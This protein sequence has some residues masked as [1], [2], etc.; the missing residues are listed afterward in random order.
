M[1]NINFNLFCFQNFPDFFIFSV[2][3]EIFHCPD[4][5][6][7]FLL[8]WKQLSRLTT[9]IGWVSSGHITHP[10]FQ[11]VIMPTKPWKPHNKTVHKDG[12]MLPPPHR[13]L[14][15]CPKKFF[16]A[17]FRSWTGIQK[18]SSSE[19][20]CLCVRAGGDKRGWLPVSRGQLV[21]FSGNLVVVIE[22]T[23]ALH[24]SEHARPRSL[25]FT[26]TF[27]CLPCIFWF[28]W[29]IAIHRRCKKKISLS[30]FLDWLCN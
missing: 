28:L 22:R 23:R 25:F 12:G 15:Q 10:S 4:T 30:S 3:K 11:A 5:S 6:G 8:Q 16:Y 27:F 1:S 7:P 21:H 26:A 9:A 18:A 2:R 13:S 20:V 24:S 19:C 17:L 14:V 29:F